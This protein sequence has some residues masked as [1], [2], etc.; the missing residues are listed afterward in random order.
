LRCTQPSPAGLGWLGGAAQPSPKTCR[1]GPGYP[2]ELSLAR[3]LSV[4]HGYYHNLP[5]KSP[6]SPPKQLIW[7]AKLGVL[8]GRVS[9]LGFWAGRAGRANPDRQARALL[10]HSP[11]RPGGPAR[12]TPVGLYPTH[13]EA[14]IYITTS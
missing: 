6:F 4:C 13:L 12:P 10:F 7:G 3:I 11:A 9:P 2:R 5:L 1:A 8:A 14:Y